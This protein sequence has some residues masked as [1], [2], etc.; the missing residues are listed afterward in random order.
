MPALRT[1]LIASVAAL[2]ASVAAVAATQASGNAAPPKHA[3]TPEDGIVTLHQ[4]VDLPA[5]TW[6]STT[7]EVRLPH[8][9]TYA[10]DANVRGRL[11]GT[12]ALNT[13]ITAR[14]WNVTANAEVP[15]SERL[16]YQLVDL[17]TDT[18]PIG[19]NATAPI[20]ELIRVTRPT[21]IEL[22]AEDVTGVGKAAI[23]QVSSD[24]DGY[25]TLRYERVHP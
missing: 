10:I 11:Q 23:A 6:T 7:L 22:Q 19:G 5:S 15:Y 9:G 18:A 20:S 14:L 3:H 8:P 24:A 17:N 2:L 4:D 21:T 1:S 12:P 25:T 16:V 13:V